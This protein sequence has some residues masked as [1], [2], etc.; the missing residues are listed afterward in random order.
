MTAHQCNGGPLPSLESLPTFVPS[1]GSPRQTY[2]PQDPHNLVPL[3]LIITP[4][5]DLAATKHNSPLFW[6]TP[7]FPDPSL[8]LHHRHG[9]PLHP[10]F[11]PQIPHNQDDSAEVEPALILAR[12]IANAT[13][14]TRGQ[15][16]VDQPSPKCIEDVYPPLPP[17]GVAVP[18]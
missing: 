4:V 16:V 11:Q 13:L 15:Q 9:D 10:M 17:D 12:L 2:P 18:P 14:M 1:Q 7:L 3:P 6:A 5:L 8:A